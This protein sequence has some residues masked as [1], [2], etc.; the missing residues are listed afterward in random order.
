MMSAVNQKQTTTVEENRGPWWTWAIVAPVGVGLFAGKEYVMDWAVDSV[1]AVGAR[2]CGVT[3]V[4]FLFAAVAAFII[5]YVVWDRWANRAAGDSSPI[6][7]GG[8]DELAPGAV[9]H[10]AP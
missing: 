1:C 6:D 3:D 5:G 4:Q 8:D 2:V 7:P 9:D 10:P